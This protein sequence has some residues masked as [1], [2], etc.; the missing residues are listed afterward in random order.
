VVSD[1][2]VG[3]LT[4]VPV[5]APNRLLYVFNPCG[6][7]NDTNVTIPEFPGPAVFGTI[8]IS[9][10]VGNALPNS[11]VEVH[12][13]HTWIG[14][15]TVDLVAPDGTT[16]SLH[17]RTGGSADNIH[18]RYSVDLSSESRNGLWRLRIQDHAPGDVGY[19][20]SWVVTL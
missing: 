19:L 16:Y 6:G 1:A 9:G 5:G 20:D 8:N 11:V 18:R 7:K 4:G 10:C 2:T 17:N 3:V 13:I 14:D 15:L 12:I